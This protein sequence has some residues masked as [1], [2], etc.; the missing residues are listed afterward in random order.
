[1]TGCHCQANNR[2]KAYTIT[3]QHKVPHL[4]LTDVQE[5]VLGAAIG[6]KVAQCGPELRIRVRKRRYTVQRRV[7]VGVV[8]FFDVVAGHGA[9]DRHA[10]ASDKVFG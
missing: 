5:Y 2:Q 10:R 3:L 4:F 8:Q 7:R 9:Q 1:M 6:S